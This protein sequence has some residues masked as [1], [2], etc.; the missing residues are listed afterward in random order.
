V[1]VSTGIGKTIV[2]IDDFQSPNIVQ[3]LNVY[4]AFYGLRA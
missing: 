4:N 2:I 3:Q 1:R